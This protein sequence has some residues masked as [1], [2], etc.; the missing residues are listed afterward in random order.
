[1]CSIWNVPFLEYA[2]LRMCSFLNVLYLECEFFWNMCFFECAFLG[3]CFFRNVPFLECSL[4]GMC[5]IWIVQFLEC[6]F[7]WN[8]SSKHYSSWLGEMI[9]MM[10]HFCFVLTL[11]FDKLTNKT[12]HSGKS[13]N[14]EQTLPQ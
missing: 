5:S 7:F 11:I 10:L 4:F 14:Q 12:L 2:L 6:I 9:V 3:M 13:N 1:M 8:F